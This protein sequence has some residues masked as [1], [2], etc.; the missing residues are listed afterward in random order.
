MPEQ[1]GA[2][3]VELTLQPQTLRVL[4]E[5]LPLG[6]GLLDEQ[7]RMVYANRA[8]Y[9]LVGLHGPS[10]GF[11]E[12]EPIFALPLLQD[13]PPAADKLE[14]LLDGTEQVIRVRTGDGKHSENR[15]FVIKGLP[16]AGADPSEHLQAA[17][18]L[19]ENSEEERL[20]RNLGQAQRMESVGS[21][22]SAVAH[23]FNNI[24]TAILGSVHLMKREVDEEHAFRGPLDT[25]ER[26]ALSAGKLAEQMLFLSRARTN[27]VEDLDLNGIVLEARSLLERVL[28]SDIT[29]ELDLEEGIWSVPADPSQVLHTLVNLCI[30]AQEAMEGDGTITVATRNV[31]LTRGVREKM[32]LGPGYYVLLTVTDEGAGIPPEISERV[33]DP[34]FTTKTEGTGLGLSTAY[35]FAEKQGGRVSLYSEPGEGT[36]IHVYLRAL[37]D[38]A[39]ESKQSD[40]EAPGDAGGTEQILIVDDEPLLLDLGREILSLHGYRVLTASSGEE[41]LEVHEGASGPVPLAILDMAMPGMSGLETMRALRKRDPSLR[42]II[43]SGF[44]PAEKVRNVLGEEVDAFINKPYNI[45]R[46]TREVRR[47]LDAWHEERDTA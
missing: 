28:R 10:R 21:L 33:F 42:I 38:R 16:L 34:F 8:W 26:T 20:R 29:L 9:E 47:I 45:E 2:S 12:G 15:H 41:A 14:G 19:E 23:D 30:N 40:D 13:H 35:S 32:G 44:H 7:G 46:M 5:A 37:P 39:R 25:I 22:A 31:D 1:G 11:P 6:I 36:S 24:L 18:L 27:H 4:L 17:L 43:S 3:I